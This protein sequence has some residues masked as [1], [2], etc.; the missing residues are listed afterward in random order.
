M[1]YSKTKIILG[2][3]VNKVK[4]TSIP[5][6]SDRIPDKLLTCEC[7]ECNKTCFICENLAKEF[8]KNEKIITNTHN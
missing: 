6:P 2:G 7:K 8:F 3:T 5:I 1:L 4:K